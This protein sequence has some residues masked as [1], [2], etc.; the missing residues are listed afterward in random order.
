[1]SVRQCAAV[2]IWGY[3]GQVQ[4]VL[5]LRRTRSHE[6]TENQDVSTEGVHIWCPLRNTS[7]DNAESA[8]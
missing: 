6:R 4:K 8:D 2:L 3:K 7:Y 1:M 5:L